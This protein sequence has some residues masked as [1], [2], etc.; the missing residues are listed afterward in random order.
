[1][2]AN[3]KWPMTFKAYFDEF[4]RDI[5]HNGVDVILGDFNMA[6][7]KVI[8]ELRSRGINI[9]LLAWYPWRDTETHEL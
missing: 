6:C 3:K 8:P 9:D 4:A 7:F 1:M 5:N 2:T